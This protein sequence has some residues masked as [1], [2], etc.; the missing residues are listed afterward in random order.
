MSLDFLFYQWLI[1]VKL[2]TLPKFVKLTV[3]QLGDLKK[4]FAI[5]VN[6]MQ[7]VKRNG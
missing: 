6:N 5:Y 3:K 7:E 1:E 2:Y 4:E